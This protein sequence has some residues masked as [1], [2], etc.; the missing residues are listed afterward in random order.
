MV[1]RKIKQY[2]IISV[3]LF[4]VF[5][6]SGK[7]KR[8]VLETSNTERMWLY[9]DEVQ[10][11]RP[12]RS[13]FRVCHG[14]SNVGAELNIRPAGGFSAGLVLKHTR[15]FLINLETSRFNFG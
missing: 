8:N 7:S 9:P 2:S 3:T 6:L 1:P 14:L 5:Y 10:G 15:Y 12:L 11:E 13:I 4:L